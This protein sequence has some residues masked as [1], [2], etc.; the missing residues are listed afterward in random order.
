MK[1]KGRAVCADLAALYHQFFEDHCPSYAA[2]LAYATLLSLVPLMLVSFYVLSWFPIFHGVGV[3][4]QQ[5]VIANFV[6]DSA[7][8]ISHYLQA[9][10]SHLKELSLI[11]VGFLGVVSIL[12]IYNM[13]SAF[14]TI[15]HIKM[16]RHFAVSFVIYLLILLLAPIL[17]GM[18]LLVV[19]YF[20]S[21][22]FVAGTEAALFI[23]KPFVMLLPHFAEFLVFTFLNWALPSCT[24]RLRYAMIAGLFTMLVFEMAK[25]GFI[26]YLHYVPTYRLVYGALSTIP[27]FLIWMYVSWL[28]ILL[29]AMVCQRL[30]N[31][32][33]RHKPAIS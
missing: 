25:Q 15:W 10:L 22:P 18:M 19:S 31:P 30:S 8:T 20:S 23:K 29:G 5:F 11:N 32:S 7:T 26:L 33:Q 21:L 14:N 1:A 17:F 28:L 24:V 9:F 13:V 16:Q 12:M 27:L 4:L 6:A 2:S 3:V